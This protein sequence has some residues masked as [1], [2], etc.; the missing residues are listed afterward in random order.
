M[1]LISAACWL[2]VVGLLFSSAGCGA[3][4][5]AGAPGAGQGAGMD[6]G[7]LSPPQASPLMKPF[8]GVW[9]VDQ[10]QTFEAQRAAGVSEEVIARL[11]EMSARNPEL[12]ELHSR[13]RFTGNVALGEGGLAQEYWCFGL[14]EHDGWV[15]GKAWHHEDR[16]DPGDMS[17][18]C[19]RFRL[20]GENL[21]F[22]LRLQ[23]GLPDLNDPDLLTP[24]APEG[25]SATTCD[26][27]KPAGRDWGEWSRTVYVR[28]E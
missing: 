7:P 6:S 20:D 4:G 26:A 27:E 3:P 23:D 13:L 19:V 14:H 1:N 25:G 5:P 16:Y 11:R 12:R 10:E 2:M 15:C 9:A 22:D 18:C 17:K 24:P 21:L 8:E 28:K